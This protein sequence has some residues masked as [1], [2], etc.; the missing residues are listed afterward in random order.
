M[1]ER[2]I[3][4]L[5]GIVKGEAIKRIDTNGKDFYFTSVEAQGEKKPVF[6][7]NPDDEL[8]SKIEDLH[9]GS[10]VKLKGFYNSRGS[11]TAKEIL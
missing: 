5:T 11:F 3:I 6:F 1:N 4:T 8:I 9:E 7:F 2:E 10:E